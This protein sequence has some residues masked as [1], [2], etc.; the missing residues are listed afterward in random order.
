MGVILVCNSRNRSPKPVTDKG[1]NER[2]LF[3]V[4]PQVAAWTGHQ[5]YHT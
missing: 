2:W 3:Y 5:V 4:L 1:G